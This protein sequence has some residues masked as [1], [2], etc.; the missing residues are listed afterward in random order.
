MPFG[1]FV[2]GAF[3]QSIWRTHQVAIA[4]PTAP[5]F[6]PKLGRRTHSPTF[7]TS[8]MNEDTKSIRSG[9]S[10]D[11]SERFNINSA[12]FEIESVRAVGQVGTTRGGFRGDH[13]GGID[14]A[15]KPKWEDAWEVV[16]SDNAPSFW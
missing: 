5:D 4:N 16:R 14:L 2:N 7:P 10:Y 12:I 13:K 3:V 1:K 9:R 8:M 15:S 11:Q 6:F